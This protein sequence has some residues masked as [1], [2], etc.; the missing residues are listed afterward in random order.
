GPWGERA[1]PLLTPRVRE[2]AG[3]RPAQ[4]SGSALP[5]WEVGDGA[6]RRR[7]RRRHD[8]ARSPD[9][10]RRAAAG[11]AAAAPDE[12]ARPRQRGR[13]VGPAPELRG[14]GPLEAEPG[15]RAAPGRAPR[16]PAAGAQR[17]AAGRRVRARV[18][19][20]VAGG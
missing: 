13:G 19:G 7:Y 8:G 11:V 4:A 10:R 17:P 15:A 14:D 16:H 1:G 3:P 2:S 6:P 12:P 20:A 9:R 5:T 18:P